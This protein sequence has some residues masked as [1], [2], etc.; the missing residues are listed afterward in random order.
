MTKTFKEFITAYD[1][2]S[3]IED[4]AWR[5]YDIETMSTCNH[6]F[7]ALPLVNYPSR[8]HDN[9][10]AAVAAKYD[11]LT[12]ARA[13]HLLGLWFVWRSLAIGDRRRGLLR[14]SP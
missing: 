13:E 1:D 5:A 4:A 2:G 7:A 3:I 14:A 11:L 6:A 10:Y 8:R 9:Q 12:A